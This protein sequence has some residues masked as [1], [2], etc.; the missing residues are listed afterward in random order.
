MTDRM[1]PWTGI[2]PPAQITS[3]SGHRVDPSI[4][5]ALYW[6]VDTDNSCLLIF[7]HAPENRPQSSL[8]ILRGLDIE[9]SQPESDPQEM[10]ILRLRDNEQR[11]IFHRLCLDIIEATR[12]AITETEAI[13]RFLS[14][15]WRWHWLLRG[16]Q[17]QRLSSEEQKG[18]IGE[19]WVLQQYLI[20]NIGAASSVQAWAGPM[21]APKDFEISRICVEAKS[22]QD[23]ATPFVAISSEYQL[24]GSDL[25]RLFLNVLNVSSTSADDTKGVSVTDIS[26]NVLEDIQKQD[27]SAV[28]PFE[29]R[30]IAYGFYWSHDYSDSKWLIGTDSLFDIVDDFPSII[31]AMYKTGISNV[32]YS[33]SLQ[34]CEPFRVKHDELVSLL[35]GATSGN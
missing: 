18:L 13:Q 31:P 34:D 17:D 10:L 4:Q 33:I 35:K 19:L 15:T 6:A 28:E 7:R 22:R 25:D 8:P 1:D 2:S 20:P 3:A 29:E 5:W 16:G 21:D 32:R 23:S 12:H 11:G 14:R 9:V 27:A 30:L 26:R 24:D